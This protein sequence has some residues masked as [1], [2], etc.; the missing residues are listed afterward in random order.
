MENLG[1]E[2]LQ[3]YLT[4]LWLAWAR[5]ID[6]MHTDNL[7]LIESIVASASRVV[8]DFN[9]CQERERARKVN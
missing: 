9:K 8:Q 3:W 1:K 2:E 6:K 7:R 5:N 4:T